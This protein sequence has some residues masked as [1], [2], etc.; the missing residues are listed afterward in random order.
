MKVERSTIDKWLTQNAVVLQEHNNPS[1]TINRD[2]S[3][4]H[5][6]V[7]RKTSEDFAIRRKSGLHGRPRTVPYSADCTPVSRRSQSV[8]PHRKISA[9]TFEGGC[10]SPLLTTTEDG[11]VSFLTVPPP[12]WRRHSMRLQ[13]SRNSAV[14]PSPPRKKKISAGELTNF[15]NNTTQQEIYGIPGHL[16]DNLASDMD[17][18]SLCFKIAKNLSAIS[19]SLSVSVLQVKKNGPRHYLSGSAIDVNS[20][21]I[22]D[23]SHEKPDIS[24]SP[25]LVNCLLSIINSGNPYSLDKEEAEERFQADI[26]KL[27][28]DIGTD[29]KKVTI[30]P[31]KD[32]QCSVQGLAILIHTSEN[33]SNEKLVTD[34]CKLSGICMRNASEFQGLSLEVTRSQMF[35]DLARVI[36]D[37][38]SSIEFTVLKIL[39]NFLNLIECERAQILLSSKESPTTFRKVYDLEENDLNQPGFDEM[40]SPFENRFPINSTITGLVASVGETVNIS[41]VS[42][43][44]TYGDNEN[45]ELSYR[46]II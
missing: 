34:I 31:L 44:S 12:L 36:F 15:T 30:L 13:S 23:G 46:F 7:P 17:L 24:L 32:K 1:V 4:F 14:S 45:R 27:V 5:L 22:D 19:R 3:D 37:Q 29:F 11:S 9:A 40:K 2:K 28:A 43:D 41:D 33:I 16:H 6:D 26:T 18:G 20:L 10:H 21:S 42:N 8:T 25:D 38:Q 39:I 35:L